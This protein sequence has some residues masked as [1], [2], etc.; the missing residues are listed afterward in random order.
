V[1]EESSPLIPSDNER[2]V[3]PDGTARQGLI[4]LSK[5]SFA[6]AKVGMGMIVIALAIVD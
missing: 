4:N 2:R 6:R 5:K 1:L 3:G